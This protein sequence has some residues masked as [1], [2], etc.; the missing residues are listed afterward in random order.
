M[1]QNMKTG[2]IVAIVLIL[3]AASFFLGMRA[4]PRQPAQPE[5]I[6]QENGEKKPPSPKDKAEAPAN[7]AAP[8]KSE[9]E[10]QAVLKQKI[11][12][13]AKAAATSTDEDADKI[14]NLC[15]EVVAATGDLAAYYTDN[16]KR[17]DLA[18]NTWGR[19]SSELVKIETYGSGAPSTI[20][21]GWYDIIDKCVA[22]NSEGMMQI[23]R[24]S[25]VSRNAKN[26]VLS[27]LSDMAKSSCPDAS[28][29]DTSNMP[30]ETPG[31]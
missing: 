16:A 10:L 4:A 15:W 26:E 31:E 11:D 22:S 12:D 25:E 24:S 20:S 8:A 5:N 29:E 30:A 14:N 1:N 9:A 21:Y 18:L 23:L 7:T 3:C 27:C 13:L 6:V 17:F 2:L 19:A 28:E